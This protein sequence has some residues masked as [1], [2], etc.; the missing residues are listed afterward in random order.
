MKSITFST[1]L[2]CINPKQHKSVADA[3]RTVYLPIRVRVV[4]FTTIQTLNRMTFIST[5]FPDPL[6]IEQFVVQI[7]SQ[8]FPT[9]VRLWPPGNHLDGPHKTSHH[10]SP[11]PSRSHRIDPESSTKMDPKNAQQ[12]PRTAAHV[13]I[14]VTCKN[15]VL[16]TQDLL[17]G[18]NEPCFC[19]ISIPE[20]WFTPW[21]ADAATNW[22]ANGKQRPPASALTFAFASKSF[23][24]KDGDLGASQPMGRTLI[25][26]CLWPVFVVWPYLKT[27]GPKKGRTSSQTKTTF[28]FQVPMFASG[29][30][31]ASCS[32]RLLTARQAEVWVEQMNG[33]DL[34]L[35]EQ[36]ISLELY[37]EETKYITGISWK[38]C[39]CICIDGLSNISCCAA[40]HVV[41]VFLT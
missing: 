29:G 17:I 31:F 9:R 24:T 3:Q 39:P 19:H 36:P 7:I 12:K 33:Q 37:L 23:S 27:R 1:A 40:V 18:F 21:G 32:L 11:N 41:S 35:F 28:V 34:L 2:I 6:F 15:R 26:T 10:H 30:R 25:V 4:F 14:L 38:S 22:R 8:F 16:T 13:D 5:L 20:K